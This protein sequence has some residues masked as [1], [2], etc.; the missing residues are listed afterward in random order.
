MRIFILTFQVKEQGPKYI[1]KLKGQLQIINEIEIID[2]SQ[3]TGVSFN[4][5]DI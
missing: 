3:K 2:V 1:I 4:F 5:K